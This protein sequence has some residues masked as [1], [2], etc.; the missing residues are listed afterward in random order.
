MC[1]DSI[2]EAIDKIFTILLMIDDYHNI[3]TIGRPQDENSS[4]KMDHMCTIIIKIIKEA[5]AVALSFVISSES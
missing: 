2:K 1:N 4:H 3:H 5:P